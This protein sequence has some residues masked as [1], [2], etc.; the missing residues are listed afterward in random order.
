MTK[1]VYDFELKTIDGKPHK[2]SELEG[3]VL[4]VVNVASECGF[5]SQYSG[6]QQ[7]HEDYA[8]KNLVVMGIPANEFGAQEP[9]SNEQIQTFCTSN[10][11]VTFPLYEKIVVKGPEKHPLYEHLTREGGEVTWNFNKFLIGRDGEVLRR[12]ESKVAPESPEL[13]GAIDA[14]LAG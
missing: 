14:A 1:S 4:L 13:R 5:T 9:G 3:K 2:L 6:L 10:F 7:L 8:A 11:H 12:F